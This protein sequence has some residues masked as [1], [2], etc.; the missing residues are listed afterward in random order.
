MLNLSNFLIPLWVFSNSV[1]P[2][3]IH[4]FIASGR[5]PARIISTTTSTPID[6]IDPTILNL[7]K[8]YPTFED[9]S[10]RTDVNSFVKGS[11]VEDTAVKSNPNIVTEINKVVEQETSKTT[12]ST[13]TS[14][15]VTESMEL[16]SS[17]SPE[18]IKLSSADSFE[19]TTGNSLNTSPTGNATKITPS[20]LIISTKNDLNSS[21]SGNIKENDTDVLTVSTGITVNS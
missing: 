16:S 18:V 20:G 14:I 5:K 9:I 11:P 8:T 15:L 17:I 7:M 2:P 12:C 13:S 10:K 19:S 4:H 3:K 1:N 6:V 21:I